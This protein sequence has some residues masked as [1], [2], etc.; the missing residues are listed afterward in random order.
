MPNHLT[1]VD[2]V[3]LRQATKAL[4]AQP[5]LHHLPLMI[6]KR[7]GKLYLN[8]VVNSFFEKQIAQETL[9][10]FDRHAQ[11]ENGLQVRG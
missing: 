9:K 11:I 6:G 4:R 3:Y 1:R 2:E 5:H 10:S 7:N 8:G